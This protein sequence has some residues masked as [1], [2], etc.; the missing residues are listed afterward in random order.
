MSSLWQADC[1]GTEA[2]LKVKGTVHLSTDSFPETWSAKVSQGSF[3]VGQ[4]FV[5]DRAKRFVDV[6]AKELEVRLV[7]P[8]DPDKQVSGDRPINLEQLFPVFPDLVAPGVE[9]DRDDRNPGF[10]SR[11]FPQILE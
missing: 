4:G 1:S 11:F 10:E 9:V 3:F 6:V 8:V 7:L 2:S 5:S